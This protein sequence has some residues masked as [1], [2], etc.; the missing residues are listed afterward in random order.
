[1]K[2]ILVPTDF[3]EAS[4]NALVFAVKIAQAVNGNITLFHSLSPVPVITSMTGLE[5]SGSLEEEGWTETCRQM[6]LLVKKVE[7]QQ[8]SCRKII[9]TS[10]LAEGVPA[11]I[12]ESQVDL[13]IIGTR[14]P[15]KFARLMG[16]NALMLFRKMNCPVLMV[17]SSA[18]YRG[19][20]KI[21]YATDLQFG[22]IAELK[23]VA[24]LAKSANASVIAVHICDKAEAAREEEN[25]AWFAEIGDEQIGYDKIN[26]RTV[27]DSD[28]MAGLTRTVDFWDIDLLCMSTVG[29]NFFEQLFSHHSLEKMSRHTHVPLLA[30]HLPEDNKLQ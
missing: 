20:K 1:M 17:P 25:M 19:L 2:N 29:K 9:R 10:L 27:Y 11:V 24:Q 16:S 6:N 7:D 3:S 15:D 12:E 14:Q 21:M 5:Y 8:V 28:V 22:D 18:K 23:K 30:L 26:Y 4:E 13:V